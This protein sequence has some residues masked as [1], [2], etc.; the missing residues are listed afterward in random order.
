M[1]TIPVKTMLAAGTFAVLMALPL[2]VPTLS[3]YRSVDTALVAKVW[4]LPLPA[5]EELE[6]LPSM[7]N[8]R[9]ARAQA[10]ASQILVDPKRQL[11][12]F[13]QSLLRGGTVRVIHYGDSPT[14]ADLI[15]ADVRGM[16]QREFGDAGAGFVLIARPW[17]WYNHRGMG[18][19]AVNWGIDVAGRPEFKDGMFGLGGGR[20]R[21]APGSVASWTLRS[22]QAQSVEVAYLA[23]PGG[24]SFV[25]EADGVEIGKVDTNADQANAG[26][27]TFSLPSR[28]SEMRVRVTDGAVQL[29]GAE[30]RRDRAGVL[31]SSLGVNGAS[32]TMLSRAF[33]RAYL[34]AQLAHY[35]ADLVVLAYG[36]NE[37]G[38][39][40]FIDTTWVKEMEIAVK[41]VRAALPEASVLLMSPM[42]RGELKPDGSIGTIDTLPRL[43]AKEKQLAIDLGVGFFNTFEAMGG[44]GTM[45]KWYAAQPRLVGADYIH[46]LP[47]GAKIVGELLYDSL[48]DGYSDY[49]IRTLAERGEKERKQEQARR[50]RLRQRAGAAVK[51]SP[52]AQ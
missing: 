14:T 39:A 9:A 27:V 35:K 47:A 32:V 37:S 45:A 3:A 42:D 36:T 34:T 26:F 22:G 21:G 24:G 18:M 52:A 40:G 8:L 41:R 43:V 4:D 1:Q 13:Y 31:Y 6:G 25:F 29:Y 44:R 30:F 11:D 28:S 7:D 10:L 49:K 50:E 23:Q 15:T 2:A 38:Y 12:H 20:F 51:S 46:P 16:L 5:I 17:A 48:R 19:D 33:N